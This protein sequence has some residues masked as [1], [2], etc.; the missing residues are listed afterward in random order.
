ML[1]QW[2]FSRKYMFET[3]YIFPLRPPD[4]I[5]KFQ[6]TNSFCDFED[7]F[8][9]NF[10]RHIKILSP[11]ETRRSFFEKVIHEGFWWTKRKYFKNTNCVIYAFW[12]V[13]KYIYKACQNIIEFGTYVKKTKCSR[14]NFFGIQEIF[15]WLH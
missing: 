11:S 5:L 8:W 10:E 3:A 14:R 7:N 15:W 13:Y 6:I 1:E 9:E 2:L 12:D 4:R